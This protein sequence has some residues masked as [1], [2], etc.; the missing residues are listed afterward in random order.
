MAQNLKLLFH[1]QGKADPETTITIP[2]A[3]FDISEKLISRK[4]KGFLEKEGIDLAEFCELYS[5][6]DPR[7]SMIEIEKPDEKLV[8]LTE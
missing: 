2:I 3:V 6:N 1:G 8:I 7:G 5:D 4:V